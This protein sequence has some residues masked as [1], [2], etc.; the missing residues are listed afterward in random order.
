M[1]SKEKS[2]PTIKERET[3]AFHGTKGIH[4]NI[5]TIPRF[6]GPRKYR[7]L[8]IVERQLSLIAK[9]GVNVRA[10]KLFPQFKIMGK[11]KEWYNRITTKELTGFIGELREFSRSEMTMGNPFYR[12]MIAKRRSHG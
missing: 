8:K 12:K 6:P 3:E 2:A 9:L 10:L 5:K 4:P 1:E 7:M 11:G